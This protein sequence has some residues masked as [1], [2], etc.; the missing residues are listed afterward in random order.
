MENKHRETPAGSELRRSYLRKD[1]HIS[2]ISQRSRDLI[3]MYKDLQMPN[4][5]VR[6]TLE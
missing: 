5:P 2:N 6:E 4:I 1:D 3:I